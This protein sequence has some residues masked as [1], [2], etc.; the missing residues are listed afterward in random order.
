MQRM[1]LQLLYNSRIQKLNRD[2]SWLKWKYEIH[3]GN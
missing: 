2:S 3:T 1:Q